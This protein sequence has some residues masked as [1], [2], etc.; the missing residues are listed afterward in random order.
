MLRRLLSIALDSAALYAA[1]VL[2]VALSQQSG[3]AWMPNLVL[4]VGLA[5]A[6]R[7]GVG[8]A[9]AAGLLCDALAGRPLG[10]T[11]LVASLTATIARQNSPQRVEAGLL[12]EAM[13]T[14][15]AI[16]LIE[17][18]ARA[19][20]GTVAVAPSHW[21]ELV[22]ALQI[23]AATAGCGLIARFAAVFLHAGWRRVVD[24]RRPESESPLWVRA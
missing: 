22:M 16:L 5:C 10:V 12:R 20:A 15:L 4:L 8:W 7:S 3:S 24:V 14:F 9:A 11:M 23:A 17:A 19:L 2:Q 13:A 21:T 1:F 18:S 6:R